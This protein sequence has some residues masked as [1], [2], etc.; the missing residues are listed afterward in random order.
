M[1]KEFWTVTEVVEFFQIEEHFLVELEELVM[2]GF[3]RMVLV[4]GFLS[5]AI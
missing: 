5:P 1:V 2:S 4:K 3:P